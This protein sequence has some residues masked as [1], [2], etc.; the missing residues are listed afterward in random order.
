MDDKNKDN[1]ENNV[2][3]RRSPRLIARMM[4]NDCMT[5]TRTNQYTVCGR[6]NFFSNRTGVSASISTMSESDESDV[7]AID[8]NEIAFLENTN[9]VS[10]LAA[11]TL[12]REYSRLQK[13]GTPANMETI[14]SQFEE[15]VRYLLSKVLENNLDG[16][17]N[18]QDNF[19]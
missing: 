12:A 6:R 11:L 8:N 3:P 10:Y 5:I 16:E 17:Y 2:T 15:N 18:I 1:T 14:V 13:E 9:G 19:N 4:E 7:N